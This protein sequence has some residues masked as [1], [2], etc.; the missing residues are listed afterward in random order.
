METKAALVKELTGRA[1]GPVKRAPRV[2]SLWFQAS[3]WH[4]IDVVALR[5]G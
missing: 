2:L 4:A 3:G 1:P 5:V